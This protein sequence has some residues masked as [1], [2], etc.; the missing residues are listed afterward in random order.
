[1]TSP[2]IDERI[3]LEWRELGF[4]YDCNDQ[5]KEWRIVGS[6]AGVLEFGELLTRYAADPCNERDS[7]HEHYGPYWYLKIVTST[8]AGFSSRS[9]HGPLGE[10]CRLGELVK[11]KVL[12][13]RAPCVLRISEEYV[14]DAE[15]TLV[16]DLRADDFDPALEDPALRDK[17]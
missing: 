9:I 13:S 17:P 7:E 12:A 6:R 11:T 3:R 15:Y 10:L 2:A 1:M 8:H 4:F 16:L 5:L 14:A